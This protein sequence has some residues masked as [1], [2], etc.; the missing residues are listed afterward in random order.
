M[1]TVRENLIAAKAL[2]DTPEKTFKHDDNLHAVQHAF[3]AVIPPF[4]EEEYVS[5]FQALRS[6]NGGNGVSNFIRSSTHADIMALFQ[7]AIDAEENTNG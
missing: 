5:A 3:D 7:R 1:P 4:E 2:I 6:A